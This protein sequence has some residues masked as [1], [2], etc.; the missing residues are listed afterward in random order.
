MKSIRSLSLVGEGCPAS[1]LQ[2]PAKNA[3]SSVC[4]LQVRAGSSV[5]VSGTCR[6]IGTE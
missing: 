4:A 2:K 6:K 1:D 3:S 5:N